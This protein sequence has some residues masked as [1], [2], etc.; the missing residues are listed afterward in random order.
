[1]NCVNCGCRL[2][3]FNETDELWSG[4]DRALCVS[5][6]KK[7][8]PFLEE[9]TQGDNLAHL[10][11]R[12]DA[13]IAR[14]ITPEGYAHLTEYCKHL[15]SL[16]AKGRREI[17]DEIPAEPYPET[18]DAEGQETVAPAAAAGNGGG[19]EW[20]VALAAQKKEN[21]KIERQLDVLGTELGDSTRII[22]DRLERMRERIRLLI[23][24]AS[25]GA[26]GGVLAFLVSLIV[27]IR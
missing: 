4:T 1:M 11:E 8:T 9:P 15:D 24:L 21:E 27:L 23:Y 2:T 25:I 14:G 10:H 18:P 20:R 16:L 26:V 7:I 12:R 6:R 22:C 19:G 13:L 17:P 5:C 3:F